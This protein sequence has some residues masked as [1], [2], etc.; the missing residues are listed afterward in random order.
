MKGK[1]YLI[2][3]GPGAPDLIT[4]RGAEILKRA[5]IVFFDALVHPDTLAL[6]INAKKIAVG[7]R[8][9]RIST[10]Q[11]FINRNLVEAAHKYR[12]VVRLKGG[13]PML[14]ARAQEEIASLKMAGIEYQ[15]VPG[16]TAALGASAE[17]GISLTC[18]G[19]SRSVVFVTP[20]V[21]NGED[22]TDW[23]KSVLAADTA[24]LYMAAGQAAEISA[25]LLS[26]GLPA[27]TPVVVVEKATLPESRQIQTTLSG[28]SEAGQWNLQGPALILLGEVFHESAVAQISIETLLRAA[29]AASVG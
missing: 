2:G 3:A 4:V 15:I 29:K 7:K 10:D 14:F 1:V 11:R 16:V 21:G 24:V 23:A 6:A 19:L 22:A 28:L 25:I 13:D 27:A 9:S 26:Q 8:C 20:R 18:R 12:V 5:D 17:V